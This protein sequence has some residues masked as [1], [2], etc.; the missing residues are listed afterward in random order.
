MSQPKGTRGPSRLR[1]ASALLATVALGV[2][3]L[4]ASAAPA[5]AYQPSPGAVY[6]ADN[7]GACNKRPCVLYP[8]SAQLPDGRLVVTFENSQSA[9]VGQTLPLYKSDD[10]GT[11]WQ[12]LA[13]IKPPAQLSTDSAVAKYTSNWTN[14]QPYV[15]PQAVGSLA[16]G[17]LVVASVVSGDDAYYNEQKAADPNWT[18][19]GDG[20]RRDV[21]LALYA[22]SD[23]GATWRFVN[24][25]A[26]GGWQGGSAGA[27]GRTSQANSTK[28]VDPIWEPHL[29]AYQGQLVAYYSDENDY[30][31]YDSTTG[32]PTIDPANTTASDSGGQVLVHR[33]WN[34]TTA[35]WSDPVI[36]VPG[37][38]VDR[39]NGKTE[40]GGGR[41]GMTT[42]AQTID[43]KWIQTYEWWGGGAD[44]QYRISDSPLTFRSATAHAVGDLPV[45][46]G[47]RSLS[48]GG[49]PVLSALADGRIVYNAAGSGSVWVNDTG[50]SDGTWKE[51]QTP[52]GAGYSR[53]IQPVD[54]NGRVLVLQ[55]AWAGGATGPIAYADVDLGRSVGDYTTL[56]N[57]KTGQVLAPDS[58]KTQDAN[59]TGNVADIVSQA[60]SSADAQRWHVVSKGS[61]VT[62]LN[63]SGGRAI[64]IWGGQGVAGRQ[65]AQW[66][67]DGGADKVWTLEPTSDG[68]QRI[69][70]TLNSSL[71]VTGAQT[72]GA[73][74]VESALAAGTDGTGDDA[75]EWRIVTTPAPAS[76][77]SLRGTA[78]NR[79]LDVP[80]GA[81]G[82]QVQIWDCVGNANQTITATAAGELRVSGKCL[83]ADAD[84][85][86]NATRVILWDCNGKNSQKWNVRLDGSIASRASGL[87]LDVTAW[88]T[89]NGTKVQLW[90]PNA[91]ANQQWTR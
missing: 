7:A 51:Y 18:P 69:R 38:T 63:K 6:V 46:Q 37:L 86:V 44:V 8:K 89:A 34:G 16:E 84:G 33:T 3:G 39:G 49:S 1:R 42:V 77:F 26:A 5:S 17:T 60:A 31:G 71:Y 91:G 67:D 88:G 43:G 35:A 14:A 30:L 10:Q 22:S 53:T 47:A 21:A 68:Y 87:V 13:D 73:V 70:S 36:D 90:T 55:A 19:S 59:L 75:Q 76:T 29:L 65:L 20:D 9:V 58:G 56:V 25:I 11:T 23:R 52:I 28:Q 41:P 66:V 79:C 62:F 27:V 74:T 15:L 72:G 24:I 81:T 48:T 78:S 45:P 2:T 32:V 12:K 61:T 82:V 80:N 57:R 40:I 54:A 64:G 83:A 50:R 4:I 85:V